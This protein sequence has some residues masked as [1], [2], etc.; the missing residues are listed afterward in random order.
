MKR[1]L[2]TLGSTFVLAGFALAQD[3]D[4]MKAKQLIAQI[5]KDL[6]KIDDLLL[7][8]DEGGGTDAKAAMDDV[9]KNIEKLLQQTRDAQ[10]QVIDN[11]EEL[12]MSKLGT[13]NDIDKFTHYC[14]KHSD[15][16][17]HMQKIDCALPHLPLV[18]MLM[19]D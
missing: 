11:I 9:K 7:R 3:S 2:I 13:G 14:L 19:L 1:I 17:F 16:L 10:N 8:A 15:I 12:E 18:L 6:A 5:K 4:E